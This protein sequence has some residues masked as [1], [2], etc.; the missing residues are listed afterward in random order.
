MIE[1]LIAKS[2]TAESLLINNTI[3]Q[4]YIDYVK[5]IPQED[6]AAVFLDY[7]LDVSNNIYTDFTAKVS[8]DAEG[9]T[10]RMSLSAI[11]TRYIAILKKTMFKQYATYVT[12]VVDNFKQCPAEESYITEQY[13]L[14][15]GRI[16]SGKN[17]VMV[18]LDKDSELTDIV[19]AQLGYYAQDEFMNLIYRGAKETIQAWKIFTIPRLTR[20]AFPTKKFW[21]KALPIILTTT[22]S[23]FRI[24]ESPTITLRENGRTDWSL[25]S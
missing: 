7:G 2:K 23:T 18:V 5:A 9:N 22:Y 10:Q 15:S 1:N 20:T 25:P 4:D 13:D 3:T 14:M 17:E 16:A 11:R 19:L 24:P 12:T 21:A 8:S 6:A